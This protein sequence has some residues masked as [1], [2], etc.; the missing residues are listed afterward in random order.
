MLRLVRNNLSAF[1]NIYLICGFCRRPFP[2]GF[3]RRRVKTRVRLV[4][5]L[6]NDARVQVMAVKKDTLLL[7][8]NIVRWVFFYTYH[9]YGIFRL[10]FPFYLLIDKGIFIQTQGFIRW[11]LSDSYRLKPSRAFCRTGT[12]APHSDNL[13]R[14]VGRLRITFTAGKLLPAATVLSSIGVLAASAV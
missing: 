2:S 1:L 6:V 14:I 7:V 11:V 13:V 4:G 3:G 12:T 5:L 8:F 9:I 10:F